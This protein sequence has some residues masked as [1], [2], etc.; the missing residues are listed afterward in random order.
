MDFGIVFIALIDTSHQVNHMA[1][2]GAKGLFHLC[3]IA[4]KSL[5]GHQSLNTA[6]KAAAVNPPGANTLQQP[7]AQLQPLLQL[8][9][10]GGGSDDVVEQLLG[11]AAGRI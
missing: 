1:A 11:G 5:P 2:S 6:G 8:G 7:A 4:V 3:L 10:P 9:I